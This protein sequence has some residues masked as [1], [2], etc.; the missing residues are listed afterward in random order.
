MSVSPY[1]LAPFDVDEPISCVSFGLG[2]LT[3]VTNLL[4]YAHLPVLT[5]AEACEAL[6]K[7]ILELDKGNAGLFSDAFGA[8]FDLRWSK[9]RETAREYAQWAPFM[10]K[11]SANFTDYESFCGYYYRSR[12]R[13]NCVRFWLYYKAGLTVQWEA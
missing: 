8:A 3:Q 7:V 9:G 11:V 1:I 4:G 12:M 10:D 6:E 2:S 5:N 13:E